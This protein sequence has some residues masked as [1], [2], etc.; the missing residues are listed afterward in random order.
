MAAENE[1][2][3][4]VANDC[5]HSEECPA[6]ACHNRLNE[7]HQHWHH[8]L[9][10]YSS[11]EEFRVYLNAA[12]QSLRNVTFVLQKQKSK[13]SEFDVWYSDWQ[14][15]MRND[16]IMSWLVQARNIIV[17][18]GDLEADSIAEVSIVASY[19]SPPIFVFQLNPLLSTIDFIKHLPKERIPDDIRTSGL[20]KAER[21]WISKDLPDH[22]ILDALGYAYGILSLL[23]NDF[24]IQCGRRSD[25]LFV[26]DLEGNVSPYLGGTNHLQ[27]RLPC[28]VTTEKLR[29]V[30]MKLS[31]ESI[32]D[33]REE[34]LGIE[35]SPQEVREHYDLKEPI[36]IR[37]IEDGTLKDVVADLFKVA[38][39]LL[40]VD[41]HHITNVFLHLPNRQLTSIQILPENQTDKYLLWVNIANEVKRLGAL[42]VITVAECW[43]AK[44]DSRFPER[45]ARDCPDRQE[46][47]NVSGITQSGEE[48]HLTAI[49]RREGSKT[50]LEEPFAMNDKANFF[51]PVRRVWEQKN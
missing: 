46:A 47:L 39:L 21:K 51:D 26:R 19:H 2:I 20:L 49:I 24:H 40:E 9:S 12:I 6:P 11:P 15:K 29:T 22:E 35:H 16:S 31:D 30:W 1:H 7:A 42:A 23:V 14:N 18:E 25:R 8:A 36:S 10:L 43:F 50:F 27:G 44:Y 41:G 37:H 38:K 45:H 13:L 48:F 28:M 32:I 34:E 33:F 17:K 3:E 4:S 5:I